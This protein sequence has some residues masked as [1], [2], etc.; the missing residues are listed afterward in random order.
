MLPPIAVPQP[1]LLPQTTPDAPAPAVSAPPRA[2]PRAER[3][4][5]RKQR[6]EKPGRGPADGAKAEPAEKP[7]KKAGVA[8]KPETADKGAPAGKRGAE[9]KP[10]KAASKAGSTASSPASAGAMESYGLAVNRHVQ[11]YKR[12]PGEAAKAGMKGAVRLSISIGGAGNLSAARV[13]GSSGHALLDS[14]ALATVRRAAPYPRPPSGA[15][16][17]FSLTLRYSR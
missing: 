3:P 14:E 11:R 13:T 8:R 1:P 4:P 9:K 6:A 16:A 17:Q 15:K 12:Y 2:V 5:E 10:E 7:V